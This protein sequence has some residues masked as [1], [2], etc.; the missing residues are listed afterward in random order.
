MSAIRTGTFNTALGDLDWS[1]AP[2]AEPQLTAIRLL[3]PNGWEPGS[4]R[5]LSRLNASADFKASLRHLIRPVHGPDPVTPL[6]SPCG[7]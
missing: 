2:G 7:P 3:G 5:M 6:I 1:W 4:E